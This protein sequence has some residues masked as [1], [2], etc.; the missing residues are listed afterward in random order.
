M[1]KLGWVYIVAFCF[2][3]LLG[4][5]A[6]LHPPLEMA[7]NLVSVVMIPFGILILIFISMDSL[8]PRKVFV[9]MLAFYVL[10]LL[11]GVCLGVLVLLRYGASATN[12]D[13]SIA[14]YGEEFAWYWPVHWFFMLLWLAISAYAVV[15]YARFMIA[16]RA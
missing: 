14:F 3:A 9:P 8:R 16:K 7:S 12:L 2:D 10:S 6:S 1:Q 11:L 13:T 15:A 4:L 5:V